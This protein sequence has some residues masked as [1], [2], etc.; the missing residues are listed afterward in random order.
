MISNATLNEMQDAELKATIAQ[1]E[2][3]LKRRDEERKAKALEEAKAFQAQAR[4]E[5][6]AVLEA[7][8][9]SLKDL[10][11]RK[12]KAGKRATHHNGHTNQHPA[13]KS[14]T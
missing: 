4:K 5:A 6:R 12:A 11:G 14:L 3:I 2:G 9:L 13:D 1:A 8:G 10:E 7:A